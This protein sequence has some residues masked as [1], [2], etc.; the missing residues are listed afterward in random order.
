MERFFLWNADFSHPPIDSLEQP[1]LHSRDGFLVPPV[2]SRHL[3]G[4]RLLVDI[5][6]LA[7]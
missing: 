2:L 6:Y 7:F 1:T 5:N 4:V 3:E